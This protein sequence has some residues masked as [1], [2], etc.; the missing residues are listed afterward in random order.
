MM[1]LADEDDPNRVFVFASFAGADEN[2]AWF[3]N[4]VAH[5]DELEVELGDG[6]YSANA[7]V[8]PDPLRAEMYA[9]QASRY[10]GFSVYEEKT[11]R[12]IPVI[13]LTLQR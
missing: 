4:V 11:S 5:P 7:E 1:Y 8:L 3:H 2:P 12:P 10:P 6:R 9:I 13:A